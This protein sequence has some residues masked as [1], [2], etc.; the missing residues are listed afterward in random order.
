ML[1]L[2]GAYIYIYIYVHE[3]ERE[4]SV[5][6]SWIRLLVSRGL[7]RP[8]CD[9]AKTCVTPANS[10]PVTNYRPHFSTTFFHKRII[11]TTLID[12][13][14]GGPLWKRIPPY[15]EREN[16]SGGRLFRIGKIGKEWNYFFYLEREELRG[17]SGTG[18][19][20]PFG[21]THS[22][23]ETLLIRRILEVGGPTLL[24]SAPSHVKGSLVLLLLRA[25][26]LLVFI[27]LLRASN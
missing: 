8:V 3:R 20:A 4:I 27:C 16:L 21:G 10:P 24:K 22:G 26:L 15:R 11:R 5:D 25:I 14:S 17:E 7:L 19:R 12:H 18:S 1:I 23:V 2:T 13:P 9:A 6:H